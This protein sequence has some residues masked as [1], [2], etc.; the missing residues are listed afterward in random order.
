MS[1]K[2][3]VTP[4]RNDSQTPKEAYLVITR[5]LRPGPSH[6]FSQSFFIRSIVHTGVGASKFALPAMLLGLL[7]STSLLGLHRSIH[8]VFTIYH[9]SDHSRLR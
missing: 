2:R 8:C 6:S 1:M 5:A 3:L 9:E 7:R 4:L